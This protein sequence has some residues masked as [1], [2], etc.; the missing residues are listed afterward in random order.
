MNARIEVGFVNRLK[1]DR[2]AEPGLYLVAANG[3]AVLLPRRYVTEAMKIGLEMDLFIYTDSE[4]RIVATTERPSAL[5]DQFGFFEVVDTTLSGAFVHWGLP[6]DLFVPKTF[7]KRPF[8]PGERHILR[9]VY[10][11]QTGRL[12]GDEHVARYLSRDKPPYSRS[13]EVTALVLA[14]T[15]LGFKVIVNDRFEG[16]LYANEIFEPI[17]VGD[18]RQAFVKQLRP[19]GKIDLSLQPFGVR[20]K[21]STTNKI[22]STLQAAGGRMPFTYKSDANAI[23]NAFGLSKKSFKAALTQLIAEE[24]IVLGDGFIQVL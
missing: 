21:E 10:D 23:T 18:K 7:Q 12:V 15:P 11:N 22:L 20:K 5:R 16:M 14:K 9:V 24:R 2:K 17:D 8:R 13:N 19:D 3:E 6:K 4:D 1:V